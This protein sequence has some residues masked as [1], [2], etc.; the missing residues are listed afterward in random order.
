MAIKEDTFTTIIDRI[1]DEYEDYQKVAD[2]LYDINGG[3]TYLEYESFID[4]EL[5]NN[6]ILALS[7]GMTNNHTDAQEVV[8]MINDYINQHIDTAFSLGELRF[9]NS[10]E[11]YNC[12]VE[13]YHYTANNND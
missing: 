13:S 7:E 6:V 5:I 10:I 8:D 3:H 4:V 12:I 2:I 11:M 1:I 9:K